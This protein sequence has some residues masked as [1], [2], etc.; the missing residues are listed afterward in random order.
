MQAD[1]QRALEKGDIE[2]AKLPDGSFFIRD[3]V[4]FYQAT[5][6]GIN[7]YMGRFHAFSDLL[8]SHDVLKLTTDLMDTAQATKRS[9]LKKAMLNLVADPESAQ[10]CLREVL[11]IEDRIDARRSFGL[12][13]EQVYEIASIWYFAEDENPA[14]PEPAKTKRNIGIFAKHPELYA[15]FLATPMGQFVPLSELLNHD[16]VSYIHEVRF[17]EVLDWSRLLLMSERLGFGRDTISLLQSRK[18]TSILFDN[19][20]TSLSKS[21]TTTLMPDDVTS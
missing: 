20:I 6:Q 11:T 2:P 13:I 17:Q 7:L 4:Q 3:N 14:K 8:R 1:F 12:D 9:L 16:I 10:D 18:E 21:S 5:Q 15:F 19:L